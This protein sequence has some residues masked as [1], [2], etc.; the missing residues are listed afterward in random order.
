MILIEPFY[1]YGYGKD[2]FEN[3]AFLWY[4][5]MNQVI[6]TKS[7]PTIAHKNFKLWNIG[8]TTI[9]LIGNL[10]NK[11]CEKYDIETDKW[12]MLPPKPKESINAEVFW[13]SNQFLW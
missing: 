7:K 12:S 2:W 11:M 8:R 6:E 9:F 3:E 1:I 10:A 13:N 5:I 4:D